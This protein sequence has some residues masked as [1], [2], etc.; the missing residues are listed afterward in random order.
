M[1]PLLK[2]V[3][4]LVFSLV[5]GFW[6]GA[7]WTFVLWGVL[8][9]IYVVLEVWSKKARDTVVQRL[10]IE[11]TA[12]RIVLSTAVTFILVS[13]A[14]IFFQAQSVSYALLLIRNLGR[15]D[16]ASDIYAPWA[17]LTDALG[18]EM[19]LAWGLI[20]LLT[21]VHLGRDGR[22]RLPSFVVETS[23]IRWIAYLFL[24]LAIVNLGVANERPFVYAGF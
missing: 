12:V 1:R 4:L 18:F 13:F 3:A 2:V 17:G 21:L 24:A 7:N 5:S 19:A 10:H 20:G 14:W 16:V 8:H 22:L 23:W 11:H 15:F 9:G 6:H